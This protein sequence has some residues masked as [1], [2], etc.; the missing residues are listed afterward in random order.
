MSI[1]HNNN[2]NNNN[3][4]N[5]CDNNGRHDGWGTTATKWVIV[6]TPHPMPA[7]SSSS[8]SLSSL[9]TTSHIPTPRSTV[10]L[11]RMIAS[12][13]IVG[14]TVVTMSSVFLSRHLIAR[15]GHNH[16]A[17]SFALGSFKDEQ[18]QRRVREILAHKHSHY[19][20]R[21]PPAIVVSPQSLRSHAHPKSKKMKKG[22]IKRI[23]SNG[24]FNT[25]IISPIEYPIEDPI[26]N[27]RPTP[28]GYNTFSACMLVMDD[29]HRLAE[30]LAYHY[31][32]LPLRYLV[33]AID[34]RSRTSPTFIF[35]KWRQKGMHIE[36]WH[37]EDFWRS[38]LQVM[39][40]DAILQMKRDRH[41]GRQKFFYR[42]CLI[43]L[44]EQNRTWVT[45]HDTDEFLV[46]N[47][48][49][50]DKFEEWE[51][52]RGSTEA[53]RKKRVKPSQTPP[54]TGDKGAMIKYMRQ[55]QRAGLEY[56]QSPCIGIPRL[57]FG[58]EESI[59]S[60]VQKTV[61]KK[62][63][64]FVV[65]PNRLD[66]LRYR[67]HAHRNDFTKNSLGK[68]LIDV[69]RV[70]MHNTP[71]FMSLHRPIKKIC[72]PPWHDDW[73]SGLR[74]NHYLGSWESYSVRDDSRRG[75]ERSYEQ[76]EFKAFSNGEANDDV[77]RPW[78]EGFV[79]SEGEEEAQKLLEDAGLPDDYEA[80]SPEAWR[81]MPGKLHAIL[82]AN[83]TNSRD[84]RVIMFEAFI[85]EKFKD[86]KV[87]PLEQD[88][89][90]DPGPS[91]AR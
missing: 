35:N 23:P 37:D 90:L 28:D 39:P 49:G 59:P 73:T 74:I 21:P 33:V 60:Q 81:L 44:R 29:N 70:D 50:G 55:E 71:Y 51:A 40:D 11:L 72:G 53:M 91:D 18:L 77:I 5:E 89:D 69:S 31:H 75:N 3:N 12:L 34:P 10:F 17:V 47:H 87:P 58:A 65:D 48:M 42:K 86:Y 82:R 45:L 84:H 67:I 79:Q 41:R 56:Y 85:R 36:E 8:L 32:V 7:S 27:L 66:T 6:A 64:E 2:N 13:L 54:T 30:N 61:P 15:E 83:E 24:T 4:N 19:H 52:H 62:E 16:N 38:D 9:A 68:V 46:Y 76:W 26:P 22:Y 43:H 88:A 57:T 1:R 20:I 80:P 14:V 63:D 78:L 25:S